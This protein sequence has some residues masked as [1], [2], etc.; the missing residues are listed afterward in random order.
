PPSDCLNLSTNNGL[1][2]SCSS[3]YY[4]EECLNLSAKDSYSTKPQDLSLQQ[5]HHQQ[6]ASSNEIVVNL[7]TSDSRNYYYQ[8]RQNEDYYS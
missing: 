3:S 5:Q 7:S 8:G 6:Q 4:N 2:L 1:D